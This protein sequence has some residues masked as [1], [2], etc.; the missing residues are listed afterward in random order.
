V[1]WEVV[2][3]VVVGGGG[4]GISSGSSTT[5]SS[6]TL[7]LLLPLFLFP[8]PPED[9]KANRPTFTVT[10][11]PNGGEGRAILESKKIGLNLNKFGGLLMLYRTTT[12][13]PITTPCTTTSYRFVIRTRKGVEAGIDYVLPLPDTNGRFTSFRMNFRDFV[14]VMAVDGSPY[15][16]FDSRL[17]KLDPADVIQ[18]GVVVVN[19]GGGGSSSKAQMTLEG[20]KV[21]R[22]RDEPDFVVLSSRWVVVGVGVVVVVVLIPYPSLP[23]PTPITS[24]HHDYYYSLSFPPLIK[25]Q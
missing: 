1:S 14:P 10:S 4:G 25:I 19:N 23:L 5:Y 21:F 3:V 6:N 22:R 11:P 8:P 9:I 7:L 16:G 13:T 12:T 18:F 24:H 17:R 15:I 20:V 2:V